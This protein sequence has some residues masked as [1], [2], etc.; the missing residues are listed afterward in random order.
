MQR[1]FPMVIRKSG[2]KLIPNFP[3]ELKAGDQFII[4]KEMMGSRVPEGENWTLSGYADSGPV[5]NK[6]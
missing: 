4:V 3:I 5:V 6:H 2:E 1:E